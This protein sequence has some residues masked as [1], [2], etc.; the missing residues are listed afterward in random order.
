MLLQDPMAL[1]VNLA[2]GDCLESACS[3][4]AKAEASNARKQV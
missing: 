1:L 3:F 4:K 2:H